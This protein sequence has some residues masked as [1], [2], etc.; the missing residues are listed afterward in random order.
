M[1]GAA[2]CVLA[3]QAFSHALD[4][5]AAAFSK[6]GGG[7]V[8]IVYGPAAGSSDNAITA[9]LARAEVADLVLLP[10]R[11]LE[12][13]VRAGRVLGPS[14]VLVLRSSIGLCVRQGQPV[15]DITN[16]G[17]LTHT[18]LQASSVAL[19]T[20]GSGVYVATK[21]IQRLGIEVEMGP[22]CVYAGSES[23]GHVVARG[24]AELGFQQICELLP[25]PGITLAGALPEE[26]QLHTD[27]AA[28]LLATSTQAVAAQRWLAYLH[29]PEAQPLFAA[30]GLTPLNQ[31]QGNPLP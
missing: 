10:A 23:V 29:A 28:G 13:Q 26:V 1:T 17:A 8:Q 14:Q 22:R 7:A 16:V 24:G 15:P 18:L 2:L 6:G 5:L 12:E 19:S 11:L 9:R 30:A 27:V 4:A 3:P 31:T 25:V 20:A 21:L